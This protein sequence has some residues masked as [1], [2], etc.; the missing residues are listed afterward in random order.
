MGSESTVKK[1]KKKRRDEGERDIAGGVSGRRQRGSKG[2][3][4]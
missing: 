1:Q 4:L 3:N 2:K